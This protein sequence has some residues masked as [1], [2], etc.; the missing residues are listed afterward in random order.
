[1]T[2]ASLEFAIRSEIT[3]PLLP[4]NIRIE[5]MEMPLVDC[6]AKDGNQENA[7]CIV[8]ADMLASRHT[9]HF[10]SIVKDVALIL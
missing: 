6:G 8:D 2:Q 5:S 1:M 10:N 7:H 9:D 4:T 3:F